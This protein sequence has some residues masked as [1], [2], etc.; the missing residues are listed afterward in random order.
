MCQGPTLY[1]E[2]ILC[3]K[4]ILT[5]SVLPETHGMKHSPNVLYSLYLNFSEQLSIILR[6]LQLSPQTFSM[7]PETYPLSAYMSR[8]SAIPLMY[9]CLRKV[10]IYALRLPAIRPDIDVILAR[11]LVLSRNTP[12]NC[13]YM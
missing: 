13:I 4:C 6:Q 12:Y 11:F 10:I 1:T 7:D 2:G 9:K 5:P 8:L 3:G